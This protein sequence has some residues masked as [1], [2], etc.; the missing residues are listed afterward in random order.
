MSLDSPR[1]MA[2]TSGRAPEPIDL[3]A[4]ALEDVMNFLNQIEERIADL[5]VRM[6]FLTPD[7]EEE[8]EE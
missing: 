5:E 7:D 1:S 4:K 2:G 6:D 3:I 8:D